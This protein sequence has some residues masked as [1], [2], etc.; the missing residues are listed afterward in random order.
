LIKQISKAFEKSISMYSVYILKSVKTGKLYVGHTD[1]LSRRIEE[2]NT[3]RGGK[4]T[5][6][7]GPWNLVYS[8]KHADRSSAAKRE[9]YLKSTRG[10]KEKK[11]LAGVQ[12]KALPDQFN[13][14]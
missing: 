8:E 6:K 14:Q 3:S 2:H 4:Y 11:E 5:R 1:N 7:N 13:H 12:P 10:S 9:L